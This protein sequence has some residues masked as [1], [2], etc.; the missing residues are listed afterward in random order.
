MEEYRVRLSFF[1]GSDDEAAR[2][3]DVLSRWVRRKYGPI[4]TSILSRVVGGGVGD[5]G[6]PLEIEMEIEVND[7]F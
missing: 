6:S 3:L 4:S 2:T 7:A 5:D 1:A